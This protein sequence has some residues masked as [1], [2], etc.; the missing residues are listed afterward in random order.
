MRTL[1]T[2][3]KKKL[4]PVPVG[5]VD[6]RP[7]VTGIRLASP[8][9]EK[10]K[11]IKAC[12]HDPDRFARTYFPHHFSLPSCEMHTYVFGRMKE[13][14]DDHP[15]GQ[16]EAIIG[17]R[18][19]GKT[20]Q[21]NVV[22]PIWQLAYRRK[23]FVLLIGETS[24]AAEA[25]LATITQEIETN[26]LLLADFPHLAPQMD[27][28]GQYVKWTD[29]QIVM[30]EGQTIRAKGMG[31]RMRG[32]KYRD[33]RPDLAIVDDPESPETADTLLKRRRHK[34]WFGGTF[35]GLGAKGWDVWVIGNLPHHDALI[36][37]LVLSKEWKGIMFRALNI[38]RK[39]EDRYPIGNSKTDGSP[40]WPE[41][42]P[43][44][45][46]MA[47]KRDPSVGALGFAREMMND[48][49]EEDDKPFNP[50][51]FATFTF[52]KEFRKEYIVTSAATVDPAGG[53]NPGEYKKGIRDWCVIVVGGRGKDGRI[54][55][56]D[57]R[58]TKDP[59]DRQITLLLDLYDEWR[60]KRIGVEEVMFK[61]L[62]SKTI[63]TAGMKRKLYPTVITLKQP[64]TNKQ[65]RIL[66]IQP[67]LMDDPQVVVFA[68]HLMEK[69]P[70]FFAMFDEFPA[71]FDDAPDATEMLVQM[72][73]KPVGRA[74]EGVG[75]SSY[76]KG[77]AA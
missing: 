7:A 18:K 31:S 67:M 57:I 40:L 25:N 3:F 46:L 4:I 45:A 77:K 49:R 12:E 35:M 70:E 33:R 42:W 20:T 43:M 58:M 13:P 10:N 53:T 75:G 8:T 22:L 17:P 74:P 60:M 63:R 52:T 51:R 14:P 66:G 44:H 54:Y 32:I 59:P 76:W 24:D 71:S 9:N 56:W 11:R 34:R 65:T 1:G 47:L 72:L 55:I 21:I 41:S 36:A 29:R 68:D 26:E 30:R 19:F 39:K 48:P 62:Y 73:Q 6:M 50:L 61:N 38:P 15:N 2:I 27:P 69:Y 5:R 37:M 16:R 64:R 28:R 23:Y